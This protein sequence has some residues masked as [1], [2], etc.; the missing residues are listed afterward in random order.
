MSIAKQSGN[1]QVCPSFTVATY[2]INLLVTIF[3]IGFIILC[4]QLIFRWKVWDGCLVLALA[5]SFQKRMKL[6]ALSSSFSRCSMLSG[7]RCLFVLYRL[8]N[9]P[10]WVSLSKS[11]LLRCRRWRDS[12][13]INAS[14]L[15]TQPANWGFSSFAPLVS[16]DLLHLWWDVL[17]SFL[18]LQ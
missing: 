2:E 15:N 1:L 3:L 11:H 4:Y 9:M 8:H 17:H 14:V 5:S 13:G 10:T 6:P 16:T 7:V 12:L 18:V